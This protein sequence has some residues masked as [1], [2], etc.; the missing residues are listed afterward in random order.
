MDETTPAVA[1]PVDRKV[2]H[3]TPGP[4]EV[5]HDGDHWPLV[6]G[7]GKIVANV[8][9]ES[10][11]CGVA[12][13]IEMPAEANARLI[14]AAPDLLESLVE[15]HAAMVRYEGDADAEPTSE[16]GRMMR[17]VRAAISRAIGLTPN[18]EVSGG[19]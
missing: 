13:L 16:H 12:D 2:G 18:A 4:W 19:L 3:H 1:C 15:L 7:G 10:F 5:S 9:P 8:N 14:S 6:M 11:H 17:K